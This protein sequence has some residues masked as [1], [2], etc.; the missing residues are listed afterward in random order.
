MLTPFPGTLDFNKWEETLG[1]G[2]G[3]VRRHPGH[4]ATG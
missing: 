2:A 4:A 3:E 1:A